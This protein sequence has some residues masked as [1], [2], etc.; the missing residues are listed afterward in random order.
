MQPQRLE[1]KGRGARKSRGGEKAKNEERVRQAETGKQGP[2]R[3]V[4]RDRGTQ[5]RS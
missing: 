2:G 4:T 3:L 1:N 5:L